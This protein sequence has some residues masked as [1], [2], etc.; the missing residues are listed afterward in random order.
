MFLMQFGVLGKIEPTSTMTAWQA[1]REDASRRNTLAKNRQHFLKLLPAEQKMRLQALPSKPRDDVMRGQAPGSV[2]SDEEER[3]FV[4]A[5]PEDDQRFYTGHKGLG[6]SQKAEV[7]WLELKGYPYEEV[8]VR[9]FGGEKNSLTG[10][11]GIF[12]S[13]EAYVRSPRPR[14][15]KSGT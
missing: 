8:D 15:S 5:L 13:L 1:C 12:Q 14:A 6:N 10:S 3:M 9:N 2:R 4:E 11:D 7:A